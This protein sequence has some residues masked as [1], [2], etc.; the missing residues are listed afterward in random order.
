MPSIQLGTRHLPA[1]SLNL[2]TAP[3]NAQVGSIC[4]AEE[5]Q[6]TAI[7]RALLLSLGFL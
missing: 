5:Q 4:R 7:H 2:L 6:S 3:C 1:G